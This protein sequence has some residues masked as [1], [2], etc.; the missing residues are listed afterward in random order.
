[1]RAAAPARVRPDA[2]G[3]TTAE[4][5]HRDPHER[6]LCHR[7]GRPFPGD[8][9]SPGRIQPADTHC[10]DKVPDP[11]PVRGHNGAVAKPDWWTRA[12]PRGAADRAVAPSG[13]ARTPSSPPGR[14][15]GLDGPPPSG[16]AD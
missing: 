1:M 7:P 2:S 8:A 14:V 5:A 11:E 15:H 13:P 16:C 6:Q 12:A 4:E 10:C 9:Y 3:G